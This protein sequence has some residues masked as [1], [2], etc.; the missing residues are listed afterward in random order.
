M[1]GRE[2]KLRYGGSGELLAGEPAVSVNS[3][4]NLRNRV[5]QTRCISAGTLARRRDRR[6]IGASC[7]VCLL[8]WTRTPLLEITYHSPTHRRGLPTHRRRRESTRSSRLPC[9]PCHPDI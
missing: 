7:R 2:R 4:R 6:A 9:V 8:P 5:P 1:L 3:A